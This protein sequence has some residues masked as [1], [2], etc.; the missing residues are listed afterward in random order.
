ML[1]HCGVGAKHLTHLDT[2]DQPLTAT[3]SGGKVPAIGARMPPLPRHN[4]LDPCC[5]QLPSGPWL[6]LGDYLL[7]Q[8]YGIS[9]DT[10]RERFAQRRAV[11]GAGQRLDWDMHYPAGS[12]LWYYREVADEPAVPFTEE[13]LHQDEHLLVVDKPH[14]L[15]V[16]PAGRFLRETLLVRL[17]ERTGLAELTPLHR[18]D[19]LTAGLVL[20]S[21]RASSRGAYTDLFRQRAIRKVYHAIA[22][23]S[24]QLNLPLVYRSRLVAGEP[25]FCMAE[26]PGPA[27]AETH[28]T[29]LSENNGE[30]L[31]QLEPLTGRKHQLRVHMSVLGLPIRGDPLYP[32]LLPESAAERWDQPLQLLA[33]TLEFADPLTGRARQFASRRTLVLA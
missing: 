10:W 1:P 29:L 6:R 8:F 12:A 13:I 21:V 4:H 9:E 33:K 16:V 31:Y 17:R 32:A 27:N 19:R 15:A 28:I 22:P 30:G 20:F 5:Q 18:L 26:V 3:R 2:R 25:F 11:D 7:Q 23:Y 14:F 24:P